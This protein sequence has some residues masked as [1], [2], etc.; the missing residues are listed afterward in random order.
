LEKAMVR[1]LSKQ[2]SQGWISFINL[3]IATKK[4]N[5]ARNI[6]FE[7]LYQSGYLEN[8]KYGVLFFQDA[9]QEK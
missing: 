8:N 4:A 7:L 2:K 9:K 6:G 3:A 5:E 1:E